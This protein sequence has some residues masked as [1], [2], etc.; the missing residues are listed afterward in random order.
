MSLDLFIAYEGLSEAGRL[1][2][3]TLQRDYPVGGAVQWE[4]NGKLHN[5]VVRGFGGYGANCRLKVRNTLTDAEYWVTAYDVI[6]AF[7]QKAPA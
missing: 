2:E 1:F 3:A 7:Q 5:G 6:C 4:K